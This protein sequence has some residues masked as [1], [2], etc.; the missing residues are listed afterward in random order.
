[1]TVLR[2][3]PSI[4]VDKGLEV[5]DMSLNATA[6]VSASLGAG[7]VARSA[8]ATLHGT[9]G[10]ELTQELDWGADIIR[11]YIITS[12][13]YGTTNLRWN[14]GAYILDIPARGVKENPPTWN[15]EAYDIIALLDNPVGESYAVAAGQSYLL[16]AIEACT[17]QGFTQLAVDYS[18]V[19][20]V[21][22]A[23]RAWPIDPNTTWLKIVN[24]LLGSIGYQGLWSD[25]DGRLRLVP[26]AAPSTRAAEF[27]Y[28]TGLLTSMMNDDIQLREQYAKTPNKWVYVQTSERADDSPVS[29][30]D[31]IYTYVNQSVGKTSVDARK[32]RIIVR[33]EP[34]DAVDQDALVARADQGIS[35]DMSL[36][37]KVTVTTSP[38]PAHWHFDRLQ[39]NDPRLGPP[40]EVLST[41]WTLP[42]DGGDM[43]HEW[44]VL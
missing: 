38:M 19:D 35:A 12:D 41:Q 16:A 40:L 22:A 33:V 10:M 17:S 32:G 26:Y 5:I 23:A 44:T 20:M 13:G 39:V 6:D 27:T 4:V 29:E 11:P 3:S 18:N 14:L 42:F 31:G 8:Y 43:S 2:D 15:L 9:A 24:D 7:W 21:L 30:G 28:D 25:W 1:M 36:S 34:V 37:A